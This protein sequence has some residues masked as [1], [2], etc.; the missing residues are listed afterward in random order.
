MRVQS[1]AV[2]VG[3]AII[4]AA[5][6][7]ACSQVANLQ[8]RQ[9]LK[10]A[11][12]LYQSQNY[13]QAAA[14]YEEVIQKDPN[15]NTVVY[16][17]LANSYDNLYKV[18]G[19]G[20]NPEMLDKAIANYKIAI[21]R[22]QDPVM[23]KLNLQYLASAY[24]P[25]KLNDASL[26]EPIV[27]QMIELDPTDPTSYFGLARIYEDAGNLDE[28]EKMLI[29]AKEIQPKLPTVYQQ[30]AGFYQRQGEFDKL[31]DAVQQRTAVEPE[32]PEAHYAVATYYWDEGYRNTRLVEAQKREYAQKGME[33]ADK[34]LQLKPDYVEAI[35]YKGLLLRL[36]AGFE[37]DAKRQQDLM[38]QATALQ[39][40]AADLKN[41][42]VA[43]I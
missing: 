30:L 33:S 6:L 21:E 13:R 5:A 23:K 35:V 3:T 11:N 39:E 2:S 42:Q 9:A 18:P 32:N 12:G 24:G 29:K 36:Q 31:I 22:E 19:G 34:A 10:D 20:T 8:A 25:D 15:I 14:K 40:K 4:L 7:S 41:K 27:L 17:Y 28:A 38:R 1:K 37:K 16:F 43:G 26:A